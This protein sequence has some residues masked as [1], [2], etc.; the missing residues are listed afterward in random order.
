MDPLTALANQ[1]STTFG[2]G[3]SSISVQQ[4][5]YNVQQSLLGQ[6]ADVVADPS[7]ERRYVEEGFVRIDPYNVNAQQFEVL[8]QEPI[9]TVLVK[10]RAFST[11]SENYRMEY[12][13]S[14][15]KL[16]I[17]ATTLLFQNKCNLI[18]T[19]EQL[20]KIARVTYAAGQLS[21][22]LMPTIINLVDEATNAFATLSSYGTGG[23]VLSSYNAAINIAQ[24]EGFT[25]LSDVVEKIRQVYAFSPPNDYTTWIT[26]PNEIFPSTLGNGTGVIELTNVIGVDT[27]CTLDFASPGSFTLNIADPYKM[28]L[29][30]DSD[31]EWALSDAINFVS[32]NAIFQLGAVSL[33]SIA[34]ND[35]ATLN[36]AREARG[37]SDIEFIAGPD[38]ISGTPTVIAIIQGTGTQ[39]QFTFSLISSLLAPLSGG[40][41]SVDPSALQGAPGVGNEGL[42][43][44]ELGLFT[45]AVS[46]QYAALN[47]KQIPAIA[48]VGPFTDPSGQSTLDV[49]YVRQKLRLHY[50][51]KLLVQPMDRVHIYL[52]TKSQTDSEVLGTMAGAF[53]AYGFLSQAGNLINNIS[54]QFSS[55]FNTQANIDLT[56]EKS[57]FVGDD[58]PT[59]LWAM[60]RNTFISDTD[61]CHVF[62]GLVTNSDEDYSPGKYTVSISGRDNTGFFDFGI[63]NMNPGVDTFCGPLYDPITPFVTSFDTVTT[64]YSNQ[65]PQFLP[66][67]LAILNSQTFNSGLIRHK[68]G[69]NFGKPVTA[70]NFFL[71]KQVDQDGTIRSI[72]HMPNGLVYT[73]KQGIGTYVYNADSFNANNPANIGTPNVATDPFAGQD[74]IN[75][76]SLL[77]V[78][79][80]YNYATYFKAQMASGNYVARDPQSGQDPSKSFYGSLSASLSKNNSLWGDFIPFK[81]ITIDEQTAQAMMFQQAN[82]T[83]AN[84][85][86]TDQLKQLQNLQSQLILT[87]VA[88]TAANTPGQPANTSLTTVLAG[89]TAQITAVNTTITNQNAQIQQ[90]LQ[91]SLPITISGNDITSSP[92]LSTFGQTAS[93]P[94]YQ[95]ELRR[96]ANLLGR[97]LSW[98]VRANQDKSYLMIDDAFEKDPDL[99]AIGVKL[100]DQLKLFSNQYKTV[101]EQIATPRDLLNLEVYADTQGHVHIRPPRYNAMPSSVF[102]RMMQMN[103]N[104]GVQLYPEFMESL[105]VTQLGTLISQVGIVELEMRLDGAILGITDDITLANYMNINGL[106]LGQFIFISDQNGNI[107]T[108]SAIQV[109]ADPDTILQNI[110]TS[111]DASIAAQGS[112]N[113]VFNSA[114]RAKLATNT[115]SST[116]VSASIS[117][118]YVNTL[119]TL[120]FQKSGQQPVLDNFLLPTQSGVIAVSTTQQVD[121]VA[122]TNDLADKVST[123]QKILVQLSH[124][125]TNAREAASLDANPNNTANSAQVP[126]LYGNQNVPQVFQN[127]LEDETYDDLGVGSGARYIIHDYQIIK[128]QLGE[129]PPTCTMVE[130]TGQQDEFLPN[131]QLPSDFNGAFPAGGNAL[132]TAAAVDYD[133][134][135]QYG[136]R[137]GPNAVMNAPFFSDAQNQ[138]APYAAMLLARARKNIIQGTLVIAGNEFM[139]P[140][141][142]IY[143]ESRGLLFYVESVAHNYVYGQPFR[144]TLRLSYGHNP[145]EFIPTPLDIIGK[146]MYNNRDTASSVAY[147]NTTTGNEIPLGAIIIN[148]QSSS[149]TAS[150]DTVL[151]GPYGTFN[152]EVI[153]NILYTSAGVFNTNPADSNQVPTIE[154][155][156][157]FNSQNGQP[158]S[159]IT[160][161]AS[162]VEGLLTGTLSMPQSTL[163]GTPTNIQIQSSAISIAQIDS[164]STAEYRSPS[165]KAVDAARN[166]SQSFPGAGGSPTDPIGGAISGYVIDC[167]IVLSNANPTSSGSTTPV[168]S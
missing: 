154:L 36:A 7:A 161:A 37:A 152:Q 87:K 59:D 138:C 27:S 168:G 136:Y 97:R 41:V 162:T 47:F 2:L 85:I 146:L 89:I 21:T 30:T 132:I 94:T 156:I 129:S 113:S 83:Q 16:Y 166:V 130:V 1:I 71:D 61:G 51:N 62:A 72:Y 163:T 110:S 48:T 82:I 99:F 10:K 60:M 164:A 9:M 3:G 63:I 68:G 119:T 74:V 115:I 117:S 19:F 73:W 112:L 114:D 70:S 144:T 14:D 18:Q 55:A 76:L 54:N 12:M 64:N 90:A 15:E 120:I 116:T 20:F 56:L 80:P 118:N 135:R 43:P 34:T 86:I 53:G 31:I 150:T 145:G 39:I 57:V 45:T 79:V 131:D 78:G 40:G 153:N 139:Q 104:N 127:M 66:E 96:E 6:V 100:T 17:K 69:S 88:S 95:T 38:P 121:V 28:M 25:S 35:V 33:D 42:T 147:R 29:I 5:G 102:Y 155:R 149:I 44:T 32:N 141:E 81:S 111:F 108:L 124:A 105:F 67:N 22:Q 52:G 84:S 122:V 158:P 50:G 92:S 137:T 157:F 8:L 23:G 4:Y 106:G 46:D 140:G 151:S 148:P 103:Q 13:S 160:A 93:S 75:I 24:S 77:I 101:R 126:N 58:F 109:N 143:I 91:A 125:L 26:D 134:W 128:L 98:Q 165:Q 142:V 11:L 133:M 107:S 167:V 49:N 123:R 159:T 65:I